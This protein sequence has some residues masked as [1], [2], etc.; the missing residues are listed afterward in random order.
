MKV[1][2]SPDTAALWVREYD[3]GT[4][5]MQH[6]RRPI[7]AKWVEFLTR[8][9]L[10]GRFNPDTVL[11]SLA[12]NRQDNKTYIANGNHTLRAI[13]A[14]GK[15]Y[16]LA[17][18]QTTHSDMRTIRDL[19]AKFDGGKARKRDESLRAYDAQTVL[20]VPT[21]TDVKLL[22]A[23]VGFILDGFN[24]STGFNRMVP[25][26]E[27]LVEM[28]NWAHAYGLLVQAA[29][30]GEK[31]WYKKL[32]NRKPVAAVALATLRYQPTRA[33]PFWS[34]VASGANLEKGDP[35]LMLGRYILTSVSQG[36]T[37]GQ[38]DSPDIMAKIVA[39]YWNRYYD[40]KPANIRPHIKTDTPIKINGTP[41]NGRQGARPSLTGAVSPSH[42]AGQWGG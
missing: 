25:H 16:V 38:G 28:K 30:S 31:V 2:V 11:I 12:T 40:G 42:V 3:Y 5:E 13:V 19:Y 18:D 26:E 24:R 14:S 15:T 39:G 35:A 33:Y 4:E 20:A 8:E 27:L 6:I 21:H 36:G 10:A 32:C 9:M 17:V 34:S 37:N 23:A 1:A 22:A 41:Y 7:S 29:K